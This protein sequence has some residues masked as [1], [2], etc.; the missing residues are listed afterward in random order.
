[1]PARRAFNSINLRSW[2][3]ALIFTGIATTGLIFLQRELPD[4]FNLPLVAIVYLLAINLATQTAGFTAGVI[5]AIASFF[6]LNFF[7]IN[8]RGTL[9]VTNITDIVL[10]ALFLIVALVNNQLLVQAQRRAIEAAQR[11]RDATRF[12]EL[13][14]ALISG[15][16]AN[17]I[18]DKLATKLK[19]ILHAE[20][21]EV[22][23]KPLAGASPVRVMSPAHALPT[24]LPAH[25]E[26]ILSART[27]FGDVRV[28]RNQR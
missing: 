21:V 14:L 26:P 11:E 27:S 9:F 15:A 22:A 1:M 7:F 28:W 4:W 8:P 23:L 3:W 25:E 5:A 2:L 6:C 10:L 20:A 16:D 13:S 24:T 18:A 19:D 12:Y 17:D